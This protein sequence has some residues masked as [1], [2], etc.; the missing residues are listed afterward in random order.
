MRLITCRLSLVERSQS[1]GGRCSLTALRLRVQ[2]SLHLL[3]STTGRFRKISG[4]SLAKQ[5]KRER[6]RVRKTKKKER[7]RGSNL[8]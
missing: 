5:R 1:E 6:K 3:P 8:S 4:L 2:S 7:R